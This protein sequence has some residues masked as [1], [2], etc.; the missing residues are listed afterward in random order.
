LYN[1][2]RNSPSSTPVD[3]SQLSTSNNNEKRPRRIRQRRTRNDFYFL[4]F[5]N[6]LSDSGSSS[7]E[8]EIEGTETKT[9]VKTQNINASNYEDQDVDDEDYDDDGGDLTSSMTSRSS[10]LTVNNEGNSQVFS[11]YNED[12]CELMNSENRKE[13]IDFLFSNQ[14][15]NQKFLNGNLSSFMT[16]LDTFFS[17]KKIILSAEDQKRKINNDVNSVCDQILSLYN[18]LITLQKSIP[19]SEITHFP[20]Y[21]ENTD[22]MNTNS[23]NSINMEGESVV[24]CYTEEASA[25]YDNARQVTPGTT[26]PFLMAVFGRLEHMLSNP[27]QINFLLTGIIARL[28]YYPQLLLRSFLLNHNL[29]VQ[30]NVQTLIQVIF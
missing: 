12:D 3:N 16:A 18:E 20:V 28:A 27:L 6:E 19:C 1:F 10:S 2:K 26:G 17:Q 5:D 25:I 22:K 4:S 14:Q 13:L 8:A 11:N 15:N 7:S 23:Q 21:E 30:P 9:Q 29:V 24:A